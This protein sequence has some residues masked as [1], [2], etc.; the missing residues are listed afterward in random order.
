MSMVASDIA[1]IPTTGFTWYVLFLE[2]AW[3]DPIKIELQNNFL[4]LGRE[5]GRDVLVIRGFD[6]NE[7][8]SSA[9]ETLTLY[10]AEWF[11]RITRPALLISDTA[12]RLLLEEAAKLSAAKLI[13]IPLTSFR[14]KPAGTI[15]E[16]LR[17]LV[18]ALRDDNALAALHRL[19]PGALQNGWGWLR[20]Y[21]ELKPSFLGFGVN[22]NA[23][24]DK[25]L[26]PLPN[27]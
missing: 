13:L 2:E 15:V 7:F 16:L 10:D 20:D 12:P 27:T 5:V 11:N 21:A 22:L 19:E 17:H 4:E 18:T 6:P 14:G 25:I 23:A 9:Y 3:N 8:Y 24:L 26:S 1:T